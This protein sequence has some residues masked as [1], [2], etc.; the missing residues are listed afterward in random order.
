MLPFSS[1]E[2]GVH[3]GIREHVDGRGLEHHGPLSDLVALSRHDVREKIV[4]V[5]F[6]EVLLKNLQAQY[7]A[8][9]E[10]EREGAEGRSSGSSVLRSFAAD[11]NGTC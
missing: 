9:R 5:R 11:S 6:Y 3:L 2:V 4:D 8:R 1:T 10:G 7:I